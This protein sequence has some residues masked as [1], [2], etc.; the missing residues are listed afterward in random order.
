VNPITNTIYA[1]E[2]QQSIT[3][4]F[5]SLYIP[6]PAPIVVYV[7]DG[8]TNIVTKVIPIGK[9]SENTFFLPQIVVDPTRNQVIVSNSNVATV[10]D[11]NTNN[12]VG[13]W[14]LS[15]PIQKL[16]IDPNTHVLY[17]IVNGP[18]ILGGS[19]LAIVAGK[20]QL[21]TSFHC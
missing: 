2:V 17:A 18:A 9:S 6:A 16:K 14:Y 7:L 15:S 10:I 1:V 21:I 4:P 12:V 5:T 19:L 3:N 20:E 8:N 13:S 11:G